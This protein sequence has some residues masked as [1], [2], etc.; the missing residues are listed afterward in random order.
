MLD[1]ALAVMHEIWLLAV[2]LDSVLAWLA[3]WL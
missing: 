2:A 3:E 1:L